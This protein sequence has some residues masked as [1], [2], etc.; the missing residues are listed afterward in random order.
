MFSIFMHLI[1]YFI[2]NKQEWTVVPSTHSTQIRIYA[3][4]TF[5]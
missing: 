3:R 1:D 4:E 2:L 5:T